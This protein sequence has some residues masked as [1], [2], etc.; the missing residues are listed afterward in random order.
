MGEFLADDRSESVE[1][2]S[3]AS[4]GRRAVREGH[5]DRHAR[6]EPPSAILDVGLHAEDQIQAIALGLDVSRGE[7]R[8]RIDRADA[9][10]E[11]PARERVGGEADLLAHADPPYVA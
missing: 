6:L 9:A 7:L 4:A 3:P 1:H 2:P 10:R 11:G 5:V 8:P